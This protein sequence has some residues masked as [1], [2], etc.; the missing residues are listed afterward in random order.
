[1]WVT[2]IVGLPRNRETGKIEKNLPYGTTGGR[3]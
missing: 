1:M 2:L 3:Q